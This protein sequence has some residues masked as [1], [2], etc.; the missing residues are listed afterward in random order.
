MTMFDTGVFLEL[1]DVLL[2]LLAVCLGCGGLVVLGD[3][4]RERLHRLALD[5]LQTAEQIVSFLEHNNTGINIC[6]FI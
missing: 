6:L 2:E 3:K 1:I 4:C 5:A